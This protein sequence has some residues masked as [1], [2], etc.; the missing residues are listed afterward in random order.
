MSHRCILAF[1]SALALGSQFTRPPLKLR[2]PPA[3]YC[4]ANAQGCLNLQS[5]PGNG[6]QISEFLGGMRVQGDGFFVFVFL[7]LVRQVK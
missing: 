3:S 7:H 5:L 6:I 1:K 2:M 4:Y